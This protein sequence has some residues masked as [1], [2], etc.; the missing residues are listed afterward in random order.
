MPTQKQKIEILPEDLDKAVEATKREGK[1]SNHYCLLAQVGIRLFGGN[2]KECSYNDVVMENGQRIHLR[3]ILNLIQ[4]F[5]DATY[6]GHIDDE[7]IK[8]LRARL[9]FPCSD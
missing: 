3:N 5:D 9:P 1:W 7:V 6:G 8:Q 4:T 2:I